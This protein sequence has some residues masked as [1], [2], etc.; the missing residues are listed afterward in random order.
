MK[1]EC[2]NCEHWHKPFYEQ[3]WYG[4][5]FGLCCKANDDE[6]IKAD[7]LS[8]GVNASLITREDFGC[9]LFELK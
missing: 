2:K 9:I 5:S 4:N 1:N 6:R 7:C 3:D 8:E